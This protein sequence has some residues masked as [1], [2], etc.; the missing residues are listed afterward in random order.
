VDRLGEHGVIAFHI[1]NRYFDF[2]P[3][4]ARLASELGLAGVIQHDPATPDQAAEGKLDATWVLLARDSDDLGSVAE[5]G[6]W[7]P[8]KGADNAPLWTDEYSDL[9]HV[10]RW[11]R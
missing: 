4:L 2:E 10:F 7:R 5:S 8:L 11:E 1:S 3:V 6:R 9:L